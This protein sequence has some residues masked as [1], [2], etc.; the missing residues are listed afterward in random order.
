MATVPLLA[1]GQLLTSR[2]AMTLLEPKKPPAPSISR[3]RGGMLRLA[4][5]VALTTEIPVK[6]DSF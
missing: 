6:F 4:T 2:E 5:A 1:V 3:Y